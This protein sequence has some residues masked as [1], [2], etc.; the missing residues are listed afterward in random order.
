MKA[1]RLAVAH[2]SGAVQPRLR[3]QKGQRLCEGI[4]DA[5]VQHQRRI[6]AG[7][8]L[9]LCGIPVAVFHFV[10]IRGRLRQGVVQQQ[11]TG[12]LAVALPQD[13]HIGGGGLLQRRQSLLYLLRGLGV[14]PRHGTGSLVKM[15]VVVVRHRTEHR[16]HA[17]EGVAQIVARVA[18]VVTLGSLFQYPGVDPVLDEN[19]LCE[20]FALG[21]ARTPGNGVFRDIYEVLPGHYLS[22]ADGILKDHC[23]WN[24]KSQPHEDSREETVEKTAWLLEDSIKRQMESEETISTFLSGGVDSSLVTAVCADALREKGERLQTFSFDFEGNRQYFQANAFQPSQDRPWVEQM[25]TYCG[26]EHRYLECSNEKL[27]EYLYKAVDAR[28]LPCMADVE[29]SMLYFCSQVS[30]YSKAAL[31]GECADEIFGGYPW[32]HKKEAFETDGFPWSADQSVR[33]SLLQEKWIRKLP[34]KE[35]AEEAYEKAVRETPCCTED[36]PVEKRRREIAYL[37]LKWFMATLLD[38]MERT[39]TWYGLSARVPIADYRIIE[40]VWNVPWSVKCEDGIPKALLRR[41]GKGKV[42]DEVLW[43]KKSPYPKT[44]NPQ[45][46]ALLADRL[47]EEVLQ[48]TS[49][50]IRAFLDRKKAERFLNSPKDY[51]KPWYGQLMAGPQMIAYVLQ[52]NYWMKKYQIQIKL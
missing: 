44:Y 42:P 32:F 13:A 6:A 17:V 31:T 41:A 2:D 9:I 36:S 10:I 48:D 3:I 25:V 50:P 47:R 4:A 37:N 38:R 12:S 46:E 33:Q 29:S 28:C 30:Q 34:M 1:R 40:Y 21:P 20:I 26:S 27:A 24:V 7:A 19:G 8:E 14:G 49:A 23:Y 22:F 43:R 15:V 18:A 45:Y 51:G 39:S 5:A 35:Y 52:I 11:R 16:A